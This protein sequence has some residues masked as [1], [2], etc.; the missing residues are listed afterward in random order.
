MLQ[1]VGRLE[2]VRLGHRLRDRP[3]KN[4]L[5]FG[6]GFRILRVGDFIQQ[7]LPLFHLFLQGFFQDRDFVFCLQK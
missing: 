5:R 3:G 2:V 6:Q 1:R 7:R 4:F